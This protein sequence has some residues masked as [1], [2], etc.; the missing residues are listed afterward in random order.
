[1]AQQRAEAAVTAVLTPTCVGNFLAQADAPAKLA[2]FQQTAS[3]QQ[4]EFIAKGGWATAPGSTTPN[5]VVA[6]ACVDQLRKTKI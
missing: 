3:W 6:R 2:E 4:S 1:M 5:T